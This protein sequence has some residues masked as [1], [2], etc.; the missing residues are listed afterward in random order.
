MPTFDRSL[1]RRDLLVLIS[2]LTCYVPLS[3]VVRRFRF[4]SFGRLVWCLV[5]WWFGG[6][7]AGLVKKYFG[8]TFRPVHYLERSNVFDVHVLYQ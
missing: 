6:L 4:V 1:V 3:I 2:S 8:G 5:V 7:V